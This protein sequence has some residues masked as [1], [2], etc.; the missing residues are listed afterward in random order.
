MSDPSS[1]SGL[2]AQADRKEAPAFTLRDQHGAA[3][4]LD[5]FR[6][7]VLLLN[8]WATWCGPCGMEVPCFVEFK[9][10][11]Q[12]KNFAVVGVAMDDEGWSAVR[13]FMAAKSINY[14]VALGDDPL[15]ESFGGIGAIPQ[16][17]LI[18]RNGRIAA[19]H[20]GLIRRDQY[21]KEIEELIR[22]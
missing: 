20:V 2:K 8:F 4:K 10:K 22:Q 15:A 7:K 17:F 14:S 13:P 3:L 12:S 11:Y 16:T 6:G 21:Q 5:R 19:E 18:D 1:D 9:N